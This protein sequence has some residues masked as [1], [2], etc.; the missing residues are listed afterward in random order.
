MKKVKNIGRSKKM[1]IKNAFS[2][3]ALLSSLMSSK[4]SAA[5]TQARTEWQILP[6]I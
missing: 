2:M 3:M 6:L 1:K 5:P 4:A